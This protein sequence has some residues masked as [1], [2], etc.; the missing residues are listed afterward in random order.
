MSPVLF[1]IY[2]N[3]FSEFISHA[4]SGL[5]DI[6]NMS[7]ILLSN[8]DIEVCFKLYILLYA[9]DTVLFAESEAALQSVLNAL[10]L[11][12]KSWDLEVNPAKTKITIFANRKNQQAPKFTYNGQELA[13]DDNIAY[14]GTMFSYNGRFLNNS[15]RLFDQG[16]KAMFAVL[17]KSRKLLL[18]ADIQL[19]MFDKMV[20]PILLDGSEVPGF[21]KHDI[22]ERLCIQYYKIIFK[23]KNPLQN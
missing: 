6:S 18:P 13:V 3:D 12:C 21:E 19:Q 7:S 2:L 11:Y 9:D 5:N 16:R 8:N 23:A 1:S 20:A 10:F 17:N 14:L 4:Y 22:L 15:Q